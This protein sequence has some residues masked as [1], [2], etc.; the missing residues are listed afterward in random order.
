MEQDHLCSIDRS[1]VCVCGVCMW[2]DALCVLRSLQPQ[3]EQ[4]NNDGAPQH[5]A[6][7]PILGIFP[8]VIEHHDHTFDWLAR[9]I[10][11][12]A[13]TDAPSDSPPIGPINSSGGSPCIRPRERSTEGPL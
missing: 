3:P 10:P 4:S 5:P 7:N 6:W 9:E 8:E 2:M 1:I 12:H 13:R 11:S